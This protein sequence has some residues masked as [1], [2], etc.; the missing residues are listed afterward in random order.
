M[1]LFF[2]TGNTNF[3]FLIGPF[4]VL[5]CAFIHLFMV[6]L[7]LSTSCFFSIVNIGDRILVFFLTKQHDS[8][9]PFL[10][11]VFSSRQA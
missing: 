11:F 10:Y 8:L 6:L 9:V 5:G 1:T 2:I 4:N 7:M 3:L